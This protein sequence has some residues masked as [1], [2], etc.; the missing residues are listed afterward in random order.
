MIKIFK[1]IKNV[2]K[3]NIYR[4]TAKKNKKTKKQKTNKQKKQRHKQLQIPTQG[5]DPVR[6]KAASGDPQRRHKTS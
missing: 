4:F 3:Q 2:N 6:E 5:R 1:L